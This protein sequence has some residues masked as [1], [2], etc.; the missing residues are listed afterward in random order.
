MTF[1]ESIK[2]CFTKYVDFKGRASRSEFWWFMLFIII[3][4]VALMFVNE[5]L[6]NLF[7]LGTALPSIT[8][9]T[10][11]LHETNR[12]GWWQLIGLI[13]IL[14]S[15]VLLF[16]LAQEGKADDGSVSVTA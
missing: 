11:R 5:T 1:Q 16:F 14:G 15:I 6:S 12:S 8:A 3:V 13:P 7:L 9:S 4:A 2:T 10:R